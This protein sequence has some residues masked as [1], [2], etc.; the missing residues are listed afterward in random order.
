MLGIEPRAAASGRKY[1]YR[2]AMMHHSGK[3]TCFQTWS[4]VASHLKFFVEILSRMFFP[5][6][7]LKWVIWKWFCGFFGGSFHSMNRGKLFFLEN[8]FIVKSFFCICKFFIQSDDDT[9]SYYVCASKTA[10]AVSVERPSKV[11]V[12]CF[13]ADVGSNH[14]EGIGKNLSVAICCIKIRALFGN[15]AYKSFC[16][17]DSKMK[18]HYVY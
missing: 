10:V 9:N 16:F 14:S 5:Q 6:T 7:W 11:P 15:K 12:C 4:D 3:H 18:P 17:K 1:A 13:S 2:C 8:Y